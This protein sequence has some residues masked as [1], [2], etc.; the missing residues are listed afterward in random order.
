VSGPKKSAFEQLAVVAGALASGHRLEMLDVLVHGERSVEAVAGATGLQVANAS[1]HLQRLWRAGLIHRRTSGKQALYRLASV[2]VLH[3]LST[4]RQVAELNRAELDR[5]LR[6]YYH[7]RELLEPVTGDGLLARMR[8]GSVVVLD[9]R[10]P[11]EYAEGHVPGAINIP[12]AEL[13]QRLGELAG[14]GEI[15]AYCRGFYCLYSYDALDILRSRGFPARRLQGGFA[16]W[17]VA[18]RSVERRITEGS[19]S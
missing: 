15:V 3:L 2:E 19:A 12:V 10:D 17:L 14:G 11:H 9:V 18:G 5:L 13:E 16:D 7:D 1:Q 8:E 4:L 6:L